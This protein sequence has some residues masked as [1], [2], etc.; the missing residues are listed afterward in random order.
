[1]DLDF[2]MGYFEHIDTGVKT[3]L[4]PFAITDNANKPLKNDFCC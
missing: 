3:T 4:F 1:M 2:L